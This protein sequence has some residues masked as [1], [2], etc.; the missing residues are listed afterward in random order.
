MNGQT[1]EMCRRSNLLRTPRWRA[2]RPQ[3]GG[4]PTCG[5]TFS[6]KQLTILNATL[7][8]S[9]MKSLLTILATV[10]GTLLVGAQGTI[11]FQNVGE[12]P[13]HRVVVTTSVSGQADDYVWNY[14]VLPGGTVT[15]APSDYMVPGTPSGF[16]VMFQDEELATLSSYSWIGSVTPG[17]WVFDA[18]NMMTD[19]P[20]DGSTTFPDFAANYGVSP[21]PEPQA[22]FLI[23]MAGWLVWQTSRKRHHTITVKALPSPLA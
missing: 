13:I 16:Y 11:Q 15:V 20:T 8:L 7:K 1:S 17:T 18:G 22:S 19:P 2:P 3:G 10:L 23:A 21:I 6:E 12:Q 5:E 4:P 9:L 14:D